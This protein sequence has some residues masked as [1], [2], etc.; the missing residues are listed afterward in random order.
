[1]A[2]ALLGAASFRCNADSQDSAWSEVP[3]LLKRIVAPSFPDREFN[4]TAY[5][6]KEGGK[7][8]STEAFRR[9]VDAASRAGGG[10]VVVPAGVFLTGAIHLKSNVNLHVSEHA[11]IRFNPDAKLYPI[12][13]TRFEGME[14]MNFSALVYAYG[15]QN[16]AI[17]GNGTLDGQAGC[18]HW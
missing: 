3:R 17:T 13:V 18:E 9:A 5:G 16:I 10:R 6:A 14:C 15:Q 2:L 8:D 7:Q 1:Q 4:V 12:V 11:T